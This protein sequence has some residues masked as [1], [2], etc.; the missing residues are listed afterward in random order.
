MVYSKVKQTNK[1]TNTTFHKQIWN[2]QDNKLSSVMLIIIFW[3]IIACKHFFNIWP[4][5]SSKN[6]DVI[7]GR[8]QDPRRNFGFYYRPRCVKQKSKTT[9]TRWFTYPYCKLRTKMVLNRHVQNHRTRFKFLVGHSNHCTA[10]ILSK[11]LSQISQNKSV[12][13]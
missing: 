6:N 2:I 10:V 11:L 9:T 8:P 4:H 3:I 5:S 12:F 1:Q 13:L 7:Y